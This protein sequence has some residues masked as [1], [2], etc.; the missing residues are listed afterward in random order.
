M[1]TRKRTKI[2]LATAITV[3]MLLIC[4]RDIPKAKHSVTAV[5]FKADRAYRRGW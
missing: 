5:Y 1:G 2:D 3:E 4:L